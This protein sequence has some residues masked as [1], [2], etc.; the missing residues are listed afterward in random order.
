ML[1]AVDAA[2]SDVNPHLALVFIEPR[3]CACMLAK[4][5]GVSADDLLTTFDQEVRDTD[6]LIYLDELIQVATWPPAAA[7]MGL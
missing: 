6:F 1:T 2:A 7:D 4:T 5:P 3:A